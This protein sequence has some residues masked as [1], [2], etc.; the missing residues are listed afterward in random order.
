VVLSG[1]PVHAAARTQAMIT[2]RNIGIQILF[3][4]GRKDIDLLI[5]VVHFRN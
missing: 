5:I 2:I 1:F 3:M 4:H